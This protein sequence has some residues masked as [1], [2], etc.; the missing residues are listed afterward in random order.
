MSGGIV[1]TLVATSL[2]MALVLLVRRPVARAFGAKAAYALWLAP[3]ARLLLPPV[4]VAVDMPEMLILNGE[5][6]TAAAAPAV[7]ALPVTTIAL[8]VWLGGAALFLAWHLLRYRRFLVEALSGARAIA[9]TEIA[10][11]AVLESPAVSGPAATG[12]LVR[13]IFVP[14]GFAE[15]FAADERELALMHEA[16][17]HRR[18]DLWASAA[19][20]AVLALHWFN[21]LAHA[22]HRAFRRDL[23]AA[24]DASLLDRRG[25]AARHAY[26]RTIM[27][28]VGQPMPHPSCALTSID[29][30]K[31]RLEMLKLSHGAL[32]RTAGIGI[33]ASLL[34]GGMLLAQPATAQQQPETEK[35]EKV[36]KV[37]KIE[38]RRHVIDGKEV[39]ELPADVRERL[40]KC[41][42]ETFEAEAGSATAKNKTVIKLCGKPGASKAE[43]A[44]TL[45]K[46]LSRIEGSNEL[47]A[48]NKAEIVSKLRARIAELR[49]GS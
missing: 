21:P 33:A 17:H 30:L 14:A 32:R 25:P 40:A 24:C 10:D 1:E 35:V 22:A 29:E 28:C 4:P 42:G 20:L 26:A 36:E 12:L 18:G 41:D 23:E 16:L 7:S 13:R 47:S 49:S 15:R 34:A 46:A 19:A 27:R 3:L 37:E 11:A 48:E 31:G 9:V 39:G 44:A 6:T 2:L 8:A 43:I 45:E 5:A 38:I